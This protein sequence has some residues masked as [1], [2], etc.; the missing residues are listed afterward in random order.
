MEN[1][2]ICQVHYQ[3]LFM[4]ELLIADCRTLLGTVKSFMKT[5]EYYETAEYA[6]RGS[7]FFKR[8]FFK[9]WNSRNQEF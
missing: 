3:Y 6:E 1:R 7:V 2:D 9:I 4:A 8:I 5:G